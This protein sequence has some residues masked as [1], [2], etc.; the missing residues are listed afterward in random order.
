MFH[1]VNRRAFAVPVVPCTAQA[2]D[3]DVTRFDLRLQLSCP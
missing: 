2:S 1:D 3:F